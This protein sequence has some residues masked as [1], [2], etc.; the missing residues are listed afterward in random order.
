MSSLVQ[1]L[2]DHAPNEPCAAYNNDS[3]PTLLN[4]STLS[5][6]QI[7]VH[8]SR[9]EVRK[10]RKFRNVWAFGCVFYEM[11]TGHRVFEGET[12]GEILG[13]IFKTEPD[14]HRLPTETPEGIRRL[15]RRCLQK[16]QNLRFR[17]IRDA[18]LE[19]D[20]VQSGLHLDRDVV[21][22]I[23]RLR[24]RLAWISA[25]AVSVLIAAV[26]IRAVLPTVAI[27]PEVR[28]EI[29][30]PP[31]GNPWIAVS[32]DGL[33]IVFSARVAGPSQLWLRKLDSEVARPLPG[34]ERAYNPFW[35][36]DSRSIGFF[37]DT[38]LKRMDIDG[39]SVQT[40]A[41]APLGLGGAWNRDGTILFSGTSGSPIFRIPSGGGEPAAVTR[42]EPQ[43]RVRASPSRTR[44]RKRAIDKQRALLIH[45]AY[46]RS[47]GCVAMIWPAANRVSLFPAT[48]SASRQSLFR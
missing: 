34:T 10:P 44:S 45:S 5:Q 25:V 38:K 21:R 48:P 31:T 9:Q 12:I 14:W 17:D 40:L 43:P 2:D 35:S 30:T 39:G 20:D 42:F 11:L 18:R 27:A 3:H 24:K 37:A 1:L 47:A 33:K 32:A 26:A 19:I 29:T 41:S 22:R 7:R 23:P 13:G 16:D 36:P 4:P 28:L 15:L 6:K 8:P 46:F